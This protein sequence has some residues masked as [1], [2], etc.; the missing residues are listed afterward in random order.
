MCEMRAEAS[1]R[2]FLQRKIELLVDSV[3][4]LGSHSHL[5][6][7]I[8]RPSPVTAG[9]LVFCSRGCAC[10]LGQKLACAFGSCFIRFGLLGWEPMWVQSLGDK[11]ICPLR[12]F[13]RSDDKVHK[14]RAKCVSGCPGFHFGWSSDP[15]AAIESASRCQEWS[16]TLL[17]AGRAK[18]PWLLCIKSVVT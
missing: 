9:P 3:S 11:N 1:S 17:E 8:T 12:P 14:L 5:V 2:H 4:Y 13:L 15:E 16:L 18:S 10:N 7:G 6:T